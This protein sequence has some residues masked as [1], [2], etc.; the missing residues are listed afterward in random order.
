MIFKNNEKWDLRDNPKEYDSTLQLFKDE[1]RVGNVVKRKLT[2]ATPD[3]KMI[4]DNPHDP[5]GAKSPG[6]YKRPS[7]ETFP[8][9]GICKDGTGTDMWRYCDS[10]IFDQTPGGRGEDGKGNRFMI[11]GNTGGFITLK[12]GDTDFTE[13]DIDKVYILLKLGM[14]AKSKD[15]C[16]QGTHSFYVRNESI[17]KSM[18]MD[19]ETRVAEMTI[20]VN[21]MDAIRLRSIG[22]AMLI[23]NVNIYDNDADLKFYIKGWLGTDTSAGLGGQKY[24]SLKKI[25]DF[26]ARAA[27]NKENINPNRASDDALNIAVSTLKDKKLLTHFTKERKWLFKMT[28][29]QQPEVIMSYA[30]GE[31]GMDALIAFL[32]I[33]P[34]WAEKIISFANKLEEA[35]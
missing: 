21:K 10:I 2:I 8:F 28:L 22:Q 18:A 27:E 34:A 32:N 6:G 3:F 24:T 9:Y 7:S 12:G 23:P 16:I 14:L 33:T 30:T 20:A 35:A 15:E 26:M 29:E 31:I 4:K 19:K 11:D 13:D 1:R 25:E 5:N 17:V